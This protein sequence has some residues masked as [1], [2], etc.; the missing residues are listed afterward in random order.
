MGLPAGSGRHSSSSKNLG[1]IGLIRGNPSERR[2]PS[3]HRLSVAACRRAMMAA[4]P[5][6]TEE[7]NQMW[8]EVVDDMRALGVILTHIG[9]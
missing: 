6:L 9:G 3:M 1:S 7:L 4:I 8:P 2:V 5:R